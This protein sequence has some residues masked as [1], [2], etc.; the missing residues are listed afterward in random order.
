MSKKV[1]V[2]RNDPC[3]CGSGKKYKKCCL[4]VKKSNPVRS[5]PQQSFDWVVDLEDDLTQ[6]SN[7]IVDLIHEGQLDEAHKRAEKLLSQYPE[8]V[9]G[10]ERLAMVYEARGNRVLAADY[11]QRALQFVQQNDGYDDYWQKHYQNKISKLIQPG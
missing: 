9:D 2:G 1:K 11:Y 10:L 3:S 4:P 5:A 6:D 7:R 8:V